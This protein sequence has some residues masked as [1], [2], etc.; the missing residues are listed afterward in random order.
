MK[1]TARDVEHIA[2][3]SR[4]TIPESEMENLPN[5]STRSSIMPIFWKSKYG[6]HRADPVCIARKQCVPRGRG[7]TGRIA[8]RCA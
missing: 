3:L 7:K 4:L 8:R 6:R 5:S 2:Q 1:V